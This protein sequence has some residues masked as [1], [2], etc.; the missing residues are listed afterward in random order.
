MENNQE[1]PKGRSNPGTQSAPNPAKYFIQW[2]SKLEAFCYYDKEKEK[3]ILMPKPFSFIPLFIC[4]TV[5]GYSQKKEASYIANEVED[6]ANDVLTI[7]SYGKDKKH[8]QIEWQGVYKDIKDSL[9]DNCKF[10][11][12][13]YIGIKPKKGDMI[14]ANIQMNGA[15]LQ[16]WV[17]FTKKNDIWKSAIK[18]EKETDEKK[19][20]VKYKAPVYEVAEISEAD[21]IAAGV[22][23]ETIKEYL[24][25]YFERQKSLLAKKDDKPQNNGL[26]K[27]SENKS[28][29]STKNDDIIVNDLD[30]DDDNAP[31]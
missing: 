4:Y 5:K 22:L 29:K 21:D 26:N 15:A 19:G 9:D 17:D 1:K 27:A 14:L 2:K 23:Q 28:N 10:T 8:N 24:K 20:A 13:L 16:H 18:V 30:D 12:S 3:D 31:F 7:R 25:D 6:L 11:V